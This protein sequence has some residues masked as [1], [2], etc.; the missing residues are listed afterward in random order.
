MLPVAALFLSL[1][2]IPQ[3]AVAPATISVRLYQPFGDLRES[4]QV[5]AGVEHIFAKAG[6]AVGWIDCS[7]P[8]AEWP[9][10]S[11]CARRAVPGEIILRVLDK[12]AV[13]R[14]ACSHGFALLPGNGRLGVF[15]TVFTDGLARL[16]ATSIASSTQLLAHFTAHEIG[17]LLLDQGHGATGL[18]SAQWSRSDL[19][20]A[21]RGSLTFTSAEAERMRANLAALERAVASPEVAYAP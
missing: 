16:G 21:A 14:G 18:M 7:R 17:H 8:A 3:P 9:P 5:E 6:I 19:D 10:D 2:S 15:A 1:G 20:R 11:P 13:G 4:A 12:T